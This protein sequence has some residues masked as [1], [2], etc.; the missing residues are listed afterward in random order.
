MIG[1]SVLAKTRDNNNNY[2]DPNNKNVVS[3]QNKIYPQNNKDQPMFKNQFEN[4]ELSNEIDSNTMDLQT[5][6]SQ[7]LN[8]DE[9]LI[10]AIFQQLNIKPK[11]PKESKE[12]ISK[13]SSVK[14]GKIV[15]DPSTASQ[16][17][18][19]AAQRG[20]ILAIHR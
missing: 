19:S 17:Y 20:H 4:N 9:T 5:K 8:D 12:K 6:L 14:N 13:F 1:P 11:L 18:A 10:N 7:L 3:S 15:I 2:H 16:Y